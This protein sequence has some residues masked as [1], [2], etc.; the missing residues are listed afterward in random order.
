MSK[1]K[2]QYQGPFNFDDMCAAVMDYVSKCSDPKDVQY[3]V[4]RAASVFNHSHKRLQDIC[5][6][7]YEG[8]K[9]TAYQNTYEEKCVKCAHV[10]E[11]EKDYS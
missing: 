11:F 2:F 6:H 10:N 3:I 7:Q 5:H 1:S 9:K 8:S 4:D